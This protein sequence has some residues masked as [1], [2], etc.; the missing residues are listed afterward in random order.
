MSI[1][2]ALMHMGFIRCAQEVCICVSSIAKCGTED[3][4]ALLFGFFSSFSRKRKTTWLHIFHLVLSIVMVKF[5][6]SLFNKS[7]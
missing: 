5:V 1:G 7:L 3:T 6:L 2:T 4:A